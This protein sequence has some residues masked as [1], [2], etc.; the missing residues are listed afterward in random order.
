VAAS[1][2]AGWVVA[3]PPWSGARPSP[4]DPAPIEDYAEI[5][6]PRYADAERFVRENAWIG[7]ELGLPRQ[8]QLTALAIVFPE[9]IRFSA[10]EDEIQVRGLKVLY[11]Q[12]GR[13]YANFSI[14]RFQMKPS[15]TEQVERDARRLL[16]PGERAAAGVP[17]FAGDDTPSARAE[18]IRRLDEGAWQVR[19]LRLFMQ[20]MARRYADEAFA[21][22]E[23]RLRFY[24]TAYNAGYASGTRALRQKALQ[25][26]FHTALFFPDVRYCYAD[27]AVFSYRRLA[28]WWNLDQR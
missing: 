11:V 20:V 26:T 4:R 24:A 3:A 6:G 2:G 10:L 1:L 25:R 28:G 27:V 23:D 19:Y 16:T 21:G 9:L 13:A 14:G 15:F 7:R 18:R 22:T 8:D 17:I 5:F 12:Y